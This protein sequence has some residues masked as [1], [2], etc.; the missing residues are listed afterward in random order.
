MERLTRRI[1]GINIYAKINWFLSA[2]SVSYLLDDTI[3]TNLVNLAGLDDLKT[4]ISIVLIV[5]WA[6]ERSANTCVNV[7]IVGEQAFLSS[8]VEVCA[9]VDACLLRRC[10]SKDFWFPCI[11]ALILSICGTD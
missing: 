7:G 11:A 8:V 6:G 10:A 9:V 5:T 4:T 3:S 2:H 1:K